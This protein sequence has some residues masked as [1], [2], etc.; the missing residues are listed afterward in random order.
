M[1]LDGQIKMKKL[2]SLRKVRV[3]SLDVT[4]TLLLHRHPVAQTYVDCMKWAGMQNVPSVD[5][6]ASAYRRAYKDSCLKHPCFG[7]ATNMPAR[8]WWRKTAISALKHTGYPSLS[9]EEYDRFFRRVYQHF[10]SEHA[11][12]LL[13]DAVNF[14][15]WASSLKNPDDTPR[16]IL[17]VTSN[18]DRRTVE[19]VLPSMKI[20]HHFHWF[21][22]SE[23][24]GFEKPDRQ[25]YDKMFSL[26]KEWLPGLED[27][28]EILHIGDHLATDY[29]GARAAGLQALLVERDE[30]RKAVNWQHWLRG[31]DYPGKSEEDIA[32]HTVPDLDAAKEL[33]AASIE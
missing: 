22:C 21:L 24:Y 17:G 32:R 20:H 27:N 16:F 1:S 14:L 15:N 25:M 8:E 2:E 4:G 31:H 12:I 18:S 9:E 10:G 5:Q 7:F 28:S 26:S 19:S 23:D 6:Y 11:Y 33:L 13:P 30:S 3:I 29:C